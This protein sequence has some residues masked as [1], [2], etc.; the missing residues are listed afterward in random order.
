MIWNKQQQ[1]TIDNFLAEMKKVEWFKTAGSPSEKHM[2]VDTV[3]EA[4]DT[5]GQQMYAV[6]NRNTDEMEKEALRV[7]TDAQIDAVFEAVSLAIGNEVYAGLEEF[8]QRLETETGE[9]QTGLE[10]EILDFVKRDTAWACMEALLD[11]KGFFTRVCEINRTGRWACSWIGTYPSGG[12]II[13]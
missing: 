5:Y 7:L 13:M 8:E 11:K 2:V 1:E 6:W 12:F 4:C 10:Q 9:E 3:Y